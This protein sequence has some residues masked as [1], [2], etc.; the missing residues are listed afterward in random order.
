MG[1]GCSYCNKT[2]VM[3]RESDKVNTG[4][5]H[6]KVSL[7]GCFGIATKHRLKDSKYRLLSPRIGTQAKFSFTMITLTNILMSRSTEWCILGYS[8]DTT[9]GEVGSRGQMKLTVRLLNLANATVEM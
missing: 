9:F 3:G 4:C 8:N 6:Y 7:A 2:L 1:M 5:R